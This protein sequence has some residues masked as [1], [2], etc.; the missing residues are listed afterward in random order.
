MVP[1]TS[2]EAR[3]Q[4]KASAPS[5]ISGTKDEVA[6]PRGVS[7]GSSETPRSG[8]ASPRS[9]ARGTGAALISP[10]RRR[11]VGDVRVPREVKSGTGT[12][13][14]GGSLLSVEEST[15]SSTALP[16]PMK[17]DLKKGTASDEKNKKGGLGL[18]QGLKSSRSKK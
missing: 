10:R 4:H 12:K 14:I 9:V 1:T 2:I 15:R 11:S 8:G 17:D 6:S 16:S 13:N 3:R 18:L 7:T 5:I